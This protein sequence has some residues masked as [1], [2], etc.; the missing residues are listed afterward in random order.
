MFS[1]IDLSIGSSGY[2]FIVWPLVHRSGHLFVV[3]SLLEGLGAMAVLESDASMHQS[4]IQ[5]IKV[6]SMPTFAN[7]P[8]DD[9]IIN[10]RSSMIPTFSRR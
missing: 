4:M 7:E 9:Q 8:I 5:C 6:D 1:T 2:W 3:Q 10:H